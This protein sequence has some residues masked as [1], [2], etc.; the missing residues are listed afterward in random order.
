M[1]KFE[2]YAKCCEGV[3]HLYTANPH[4]TCYNVFPIHTSTGC[5]LFYLKPQ[6]RKVK[7]KSNICYLLNKWKLEL[8]LFQLFKNI[9]FCTLQMFIQY[10]IFSTITHQ[11][12]YRER[13]WR[14]WWSNHKSHGFSIWSQ[15]HSY[16]RGEDE[17]E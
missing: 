6:I 9:H 7:Q 15:T 14:G 17:Q 3:H 5:I 11:W 16:Q 12:G 8:E 4:N 13:M 1:A 10:L 2:I